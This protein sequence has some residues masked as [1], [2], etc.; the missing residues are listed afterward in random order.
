MKRDLLAHLARFS[1]A[2]RSAGIRIALGDELDA[3]SA[4]LRA[5]IGDALEVKLA[6]RCALK[7]RRRDYDRF[8]SLFASH[9]LELGIE[10][11]LPPPAC[12]H[13]PSQLQQSSSRG[14][15][16]GEV[17]REVPDGDE[18]GFSSEEQLRHKPFEACSDRDLIE[19]ERAMLR[20]ARR[21]ATRKSRRMA[22]VRSRGVA[23]L[24]RS[25]R[26]ALA[27]GGELI[28]LARRDHPIETPRLVILCD[29]SGSMDAQV[30]FTLAFMRAL[31]R[32]AKDTE[33]FAFNTELV[34]ITR[35]LGP[36]R[37]DLILDRLAAEVPDWSGGTRI[38]ECLERFAGHHLR[39]R[40][41]SRTVVIILSD[42][43]DRGEPALIG[44]ALQRIRARARKVIWLNPLMSDPRFEPTARGMAAALP[45]IDRLAPVHDL[46]SLERLIPH[47][48][49]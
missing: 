48:S 29:T 26:R 46:H 33:L 23:D 13:G 10:N 19:L 22:P 20:L 39:E 44:S 15:V 40:V 47:L 8:E 3:T 45:F 6:L 27:T 30:R 49:S 38:G 24:R 36:G 2:L 11:Q 32:V 43:L 18:P 31:K 1:A 5:D 35:W 4:L 21:L 17:E 12:E 37:I 14:R 7:V 34:R 28:S 9:W 42:G 41:D 16:Q 25:L